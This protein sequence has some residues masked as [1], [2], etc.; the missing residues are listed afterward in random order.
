MHKFGNIIYGHF[1]F[2][3]VYFLKFTK[4]KIIGCTSSDKKYVFYK[5]SNIPGTALLI[6]ISHLSDNHL[7]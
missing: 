4:V 3:D 5:L 1:Y 6:L 7:N 2:Y